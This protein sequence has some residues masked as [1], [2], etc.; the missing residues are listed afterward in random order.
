MNTSPGRLA[1][2]TGNF[3]VNLPLELVT[4]TSPVLGSLTLTSAPPTSASFVPIERL[5]AS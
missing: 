5:D 2:P 4:V 3:N 1:E